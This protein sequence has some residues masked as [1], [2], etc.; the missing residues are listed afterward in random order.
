MASK[1]P[2]PPLAYAL[3]SFASLAWAG[4]IVVAR[5]MHTAVPP[6]SLAF[7]RWTT[8]FL[9]L[10]PIFLPRLY[11]RRAALRREWK[12]VLMLGLIGVAGFTALQYTA[13]NTISAVNVALINAVSP[14]VIPVL[15]RLFWREGLSLRQ[16]LGI[17]VS[18]FGAS[19]VVLRGDPSLILAQ[20]L[21]RGD[22]VMLV[23]TLCWSIYVT[24][25]S[26]RPDDLDSATLLVASIIPALVLLLPVW[27][28]EI[29]WI[30][31]M[32]IDTATVLAIAYIGPVATALAYLGYTAA[33]PAVG[34]TRAGL[35]IHLMPPFAAVLGMIFLNEHLQAF[36][37]LG[38]AAIFAGLYMTT[39][40]VQPARPRGV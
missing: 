38:A 17:G 12:L 40:N 39:A 35:F 32:R 33:V 34:P 2:A 11:R 4:N 18:L 28:W 25:L 36:H 30:R 5:A 7:W 22:A 3:L 31:P 10:L 1:H 19:F 8:A 14:V 27:L 15:A 16:A 13:L 23:A 20:G 26:R 29:T 9:I 24:L 6:V 21:A 37:Y